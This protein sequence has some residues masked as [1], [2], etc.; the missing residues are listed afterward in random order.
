VNEP[1]N[2]A[3]LIHHYGDAYEVNM[4]RGRYQAR[5]CDDGSVLTADTA[6]ELLDEI[7]ADYA[8]HAVSRRMAGVDRPQTPGCRFLPED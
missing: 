7:R 6:Q 3:Y 2:L 1:V 5:R 4:R 8:A